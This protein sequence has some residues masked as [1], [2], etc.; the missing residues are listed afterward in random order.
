MHLFITSFYNESVAA[1]NFSEENQ[2]VPLRL[3]MP[4][5]CDRVSIDPQINFC[6]VYT[7]Y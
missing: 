1:E 4:I 3:P 6:Q 2:M 7:D 5:Y